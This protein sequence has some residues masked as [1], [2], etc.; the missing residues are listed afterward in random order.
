M[1]TKTI[2][3]TRAD[4]VFDTF[5][6]IFMTLLLIVVIYPLWFIIIASFSDPNAVNGGRV[7]LWPT[8][9]MLDGYQRIFSMPKIWMGYWNT[10]QYT[11]V[12]TF[13]SVAIT[14]AGGYSLS[15]KYL[16]GVGILMGLMTFTMFFNGG[17]IPT[18]LVVRRLNIIDTLWAMVL[19]GAVSIWNL[20]MCRTFFKTTIPME[21]EEAAELDGC[22]Q[23]G[24]F[25]RIA[26]PLTKALMAIMILYYMVGY[27]NEYFKGIIYLEDARKHPLQL[28][29]RDILITNSAGDMTQDIRDK[30]Q[31]Q[32]TAELLKYGVII[33]STVPLLVVYPFVQKFFIKGVMIGSIKG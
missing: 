10:I 20:I 30:I 7:W 21:L 28:I 13:I 5:N 11:I 1:A 18:Y 17:L 2:H 22:G 16:P 14:V 29:L 4:K 26:V 27:W 15:K 31:K 6:Y 24:F 3:S 23:I 19:P 32:K 9:I 25:F 8:D 33:V 12:G